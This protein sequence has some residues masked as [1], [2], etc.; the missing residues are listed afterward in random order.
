MKGSSMKKLLPLFIVASLILVP[1]IL[2]VYSN[3]NKTAVAKAK[4]AK[5]K[6]PTL[7]E[8]LTKIEERVSKLEDRL[9]AIE[10]ND[11][12]EETEE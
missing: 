4:E 3:S 5:A 11:K 6:R 12:T 8:R 2:G 9:T 1:N 10:S 7:N